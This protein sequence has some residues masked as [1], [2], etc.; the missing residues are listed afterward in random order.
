[1]AQQLTWHQEVPSTGPGLYSQWWVMRQASPEVR[2]LLDGQGGDELLG[3]YHYFFVTLVLAR[4]RALLKN[5]A[6]AEIPALM[7]ELTAIESLTGV[8][9]RSALQRYAWR[10]LRNLLQHRTPALSSRA[11]G[12]SHALWEAAR[13][14]PIVRARPR[15]LQDDFGNALYY[16]TT[17]DSLPALLHWEDRNSMAFSIEARLPFLD[18]RLVEFCLGLAPELRIRGTVTKWVLRRALEDILPSEITQRKSKMGF[19]TPFA[20][21][22]RGIRLKDVEEVLL[23]AESRKRDILDQ[24][25]VKRALE[26][27]RQGG[28]D[29]GARIWRWLTL[30][31]WFR[32]FID[33]AGCERPYPKP[34]SFAKDASWAP[35]GGAHA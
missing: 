22:S 6:V 16:S 19:P 2:V 7:R 25:A 13:A 20:S 9:L 14:R 35:A 17:V 31:F 27:H 18:P 32:Q 30:E 33:G 10:Q 15:R 12:T 34:A 8:Q 3:G 4:A 29:H 23:S 26:E 5:R 1:V 28:R 24:Q 11:A 21:W